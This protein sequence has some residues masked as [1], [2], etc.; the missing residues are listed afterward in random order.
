M[1]PHKSIH[2]SKLLQA[3]QKKRVISKIQP[4][5]TLSKPQP[6]PEHEP[7]IPSEG[8]IHAQDEQEALPIQSQE[9][10]PMEPIMESKKSFPEQ[11]YNKKI[12][13]KVEQ[14]ETRKLF[15]EYEQFKYEQDLWN[16]LNGKY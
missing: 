9:A 13:I 7:F 1:L 4:E 6:I 2:Q 15:E 10:I 5:M 12:A 16:R 8:P 11:I 3:L 14:S